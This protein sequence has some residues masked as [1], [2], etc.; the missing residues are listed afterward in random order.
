MTTSLTSPPGQFRRWLHS[1][2][3]LLIPRRCPVCHHRLALTEEYLCASCLFGLP[4]V[5]HTSFTHN[6]MARRFWGVLPI[7]HAT[8]FFR[9]QRG[10]NYSRI[11][12]DLKYRHHP[13]VGVL[14][15]R[16]LATRLIPQ[17]FFEGIDVLVPIPLSARRERKRGY[18]Q[19]LKIAEGVAVATGLPIAA[20]ALRRTVDNAS[21]TQVGRAERAT[22]VQGIFS[23]HRPETLTGRHVLLIDDVMTTGATLLAC[24]ETFSH[25]PDVKISIL[26]LALT[27]G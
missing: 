12:L 10:S 24:G 14:L 19:S 6:P 7:E 20:D 3:D 4:T 17:G 2:I 16:M 27:E 23:L 18:N 26:T 22:N 9:Y 11:L 21:Q 1:L 8:A 25:L 13:E 5:H 15:G